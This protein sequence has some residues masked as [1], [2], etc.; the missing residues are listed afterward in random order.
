MCSRKANMG[1]EEAVSLALQVVAE[2][3]LLAG[4]GRSSGTERTAA[5]F[6]T[7]AVQAFAVG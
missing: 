2:R 3:R 4:T 7:P 1:S 6:R 5:L